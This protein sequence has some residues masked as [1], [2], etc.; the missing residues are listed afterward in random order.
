V[1]VR[2]RIPPN[3]F[4]S[5]VLRSRPGRWGLGLATLVLLVVLGV[6]SY[7]WIYFSHIIDAKLSGN[8][9]ANTAQLY[10][11][12]EPINTGDSLTTEELVAAL[13]RRGYTTSQRNRAGWYNVRAD[14]VEIFPGAD[15]APDAE[16]GVIFLNKGV[17]TRIVSDRDNTVR[18][19]YLLEP[20]LITNLFD[21]KRQKRRLV[22]FDDIPKVLV[23]AILSAEDKRFFQH[24][25]FD[26]VGI[27][28]A[29]YQDVRGGKISQGAS[30]LT[31]QVARTF[32]LN[33]DRTWKRKAAEVLITL[34]LEHRL[35]KEQI[36][37]FYVNYVDLGWRRSFQVQGFGEAAQ[38]HFGKDVRE[39]T[40]EEAALL[41][42]M[43]QGPN[44]YNPYRSPDKALAR[45]NTVL[46][47]MKENGYITETQYN[48]AIRTPIKLREGGIESS[49]APYF[50]DLVSD[51]LQEQFSDHDFQSR[52]YKIYTTLDLKLQRDAVEA[53]RLGMAEVDALLAKR[54]KKY[55]EAQV[56]LVALDP[57]TGEVKAL[58]GGRS[59]GQSQLNRVL[60]LRQPGSSFKPFVYAA[61][62]NSAL[63]N[64]D[65]T[66][67]T[68]TT[69]ADEPTKFEYDG[70]VYEPGNF[71]DKFY[72]TVSMRFALAKSL[73]IPTIKFAERAGLDEVVR[74]AR[75]SG[76]N[77][78]IKATPAVALGS[79]DV[80][81]LEIAGAYTVFSND[82]VA[83]KPSWIREIRSETGGLVFNSQPVK[84]EV[85]DPRISYMVVNL[86]E[87]VLRS[88]TG[89]GARGRGFD[90]PA[91]GKTGTSHDAWFA[92]FTSKL[93]CVVWVGFDDNQELP[94][95]GAKAALPVWTEFMKRAHR[96]REYH[97]VQSFAAPDG[98]V[99]AEVDADT[100]ML[101]TAAC[102]HTRA[103]VFLAGTQPVDLCS[104]H[105]GGGRQTMIAGWETPG[106]KAAASPNSPPGRRARVEPAAP[107]TSSAN[108]D[109]PK[110]EK[111]GFW[112]RIRDI[113]R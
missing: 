44:L 90:L 8:P 11:A 74:I 113:F 21:R 12:P 40:V 49:D 103:E 76:M 105:G 14:G 73:N 24:A 16:A 43:A 98:I 41:A 52:S 6:F 112:G 35:S 102:P 71:G 104:L 45:R 96:Y 82:G 88:G 55:P 80:T 4:L 56:A 66:L 109:P 10:S 84:H 65:T 47:M 110:K 61:A 59:Y 111:R 18:T 97:G 92:G 57:H 48:D 94:L 34:Q 28:R 60:A 107:V 77:K 63:Q 15:S 22:R 36:F 46:G 106:E 17:V 32:F 86:M 70:K 69:V 13:K 51:H 67:T 1:A 101:A 42:G 87:E 64:G 81:P 93:L 83:L 91:A 85:L 100:G 5:R 95:E 25:G 38:V 20:E 75:E 58:V 78:G 23:N 29:A 99:T 79:Y 9:F 89:A 53:V 72:G 108:P 37:E 50:V 62:L 68:L 30:T 26:P 2:L 3:S 39:L 31:M 33:L 27:L 54:K 19:Q 7:F